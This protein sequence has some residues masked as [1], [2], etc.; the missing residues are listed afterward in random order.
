MAKTAKMA[1]FDEKKRFLMENA[2]KNVRKCVRGW[3][4]NAIVMSCARRVFQKVTAGVS[5]VK[6]SVRQNEMGG[7]FGEICYFFVMVF[8]RSCFNF[9]A[10]ILGVGR[11]SGIVPPSSAIV[12]RTFLPTAKWVSFANSFPLM[13]SRI[14]HGVVRVSTSF[15]IKVG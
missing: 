7:S 4:K 1:K 2:V 3:L 10:L 9:L 15:F 12:W 11:F 5:V 14:I 13:F 8:L 6:Q